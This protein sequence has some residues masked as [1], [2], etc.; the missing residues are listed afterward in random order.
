[1]DDNYGLDAKDRNFLTLVSSAYLYL[2]LKPI[3]LFT[4]SYDGA[5]SAEDAA[6]R[7]DYWPTS[8]KLRGSHSASHFGLRHREGPSF[9]RFHKTLHGGQA[10]LALLNRKKGGG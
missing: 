1:M 10:T 4:L 5:T 2:H 3:V 8:P 7:T 6:V 9:R